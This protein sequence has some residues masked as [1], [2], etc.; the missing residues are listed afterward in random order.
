MF[1]RGYK[2]ADAGKINRI[3]I[4][5]HMDNFGI[6]RNDEHIVTQGV[7]EAD[8]EAIAYGM[9]KLFA[10]AI[11]VLDLNASQRQKVEAMKLLMEAAVAEAKSKGLE[12]MHVFVKRPSLADI[13]R[14]HFSFVDCS[15][16]ALVCRL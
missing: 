10:E 16:D 1:L 14:K 9:V 6:P 7:I 15:G 2:S 11:M 8:G 4:S 3:W 12:Q 13:L 5:H